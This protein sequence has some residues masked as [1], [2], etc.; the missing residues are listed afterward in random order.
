MGVR[1]SVFVPLL[2]GIIVSGIDEYADGCRIPKGAEWYSF[3]LGGGTGLWVLGGGGGSRAPKPKNRVDV[4]YF[5]FWR[6]LI[7]PPKNHKRHKT[8]ACTRSSVRIYHK[9]L[10]V[11]FNENVHW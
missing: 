11:L 4:H 3:C 1:I 7:Y 10:K 6:L 8:D 2:C 9:K 5:F